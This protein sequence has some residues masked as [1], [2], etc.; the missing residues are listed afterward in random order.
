MN[1]QKLKTIYVERNINPE[2]F[3]FD[4]AKESMLRIHPFN[5]LKNLNISVSN[6]WYSEEECLVE[7]NCHSHPLEPWVLRFKQA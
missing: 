6:I 5:S 7:F 3:G 4:K 2:E 1:L